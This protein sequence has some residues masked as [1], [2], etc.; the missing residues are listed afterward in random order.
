MWLDP[1]S[2]VCCVMITGSCG[3]S[4]Q[5]EGMESQVSDSCFEDFYLN[6]VIP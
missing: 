6:N 1:T 3:V 5:M 4:G 2:N